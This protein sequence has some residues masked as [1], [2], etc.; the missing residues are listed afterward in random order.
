VALRLR[1]LGYERA[2]A[3]TGGFS[4]WEQAELPVQPLVRG[5]P[6]Q[7]AVHHQPM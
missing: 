4:A 1:E 3:L 2:F 7:N 5:D 6:H